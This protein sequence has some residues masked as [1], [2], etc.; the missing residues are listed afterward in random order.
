MTRNR[1]C[2]T[3][4]RLCLSFLYRNIFTAVWLLPSQRTYGN[5]PRSGEIDLLQSR[6][7]LNYTDKDGVQIGAQQ[8]TST[9]HFGPESNQDGFRSAQFP[10][11]NVTGYD[12][13]FHKY[14]FVWNESGIRFFVD[15]D[16]TGFVAAGDGFWERGGFSGDD[17]VWSTG[18]EMAPFDQ[19]VHF[20]LLITFKS[21]EII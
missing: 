11:N 12:N 2:L 17:D 3:N 13:D 14:G 15:D 8:V 7:N 10:K 19:E 20:I 9:L 1:T 21:V 16:E 4:Y 18:T 5:W 6:G